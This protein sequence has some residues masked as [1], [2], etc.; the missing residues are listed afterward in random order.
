MARH[1][2]SGKKSKRVADVLSD[3]RSTLGK[4]LKRGS[5]LMQLQHLLSGVLDPSLAKRFQVANVRDG[6][7]VLVTPAAA[8]ATLLRMQSHELVGA[9]REAGYRDIESIEVRIAPL[10]EQPKSKRQKRP[11]SPAAR[12]ALEIMARVGPD[13]EE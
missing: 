11:L 8:W 10:V 1:S 7:L 2:H 9:L 13:K 6:K 5:L 12:R 3:H 4:L